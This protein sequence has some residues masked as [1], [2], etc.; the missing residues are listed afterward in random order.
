MTI[1]ALIKS[2]NV[3]DDLLPE[4][5]SRREKAIL[6]TNLYN[7]SFGQEKSK[8][9]AILATILKK[10]G[11]NVHFEPVFRCEF[12]SNI[13]LGDNFY[14]NYDCVMLDPHDI[15]I[16][17]NVIFGPRVSLFT[18]N[19]AIDSL[20]RIQGGCYAK[21]IHV[22]DNVWIGGNVTVLPGVTIGRNA[23]IGAGSVVTRSVPADVIA[24]GNPCRVIR[25]ITEK[26]KKQGWGKIVS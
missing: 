2:G 17:N 23:I 26:D 25:K 18:A 11:R 15:V 1:D 4:I 20:E 9:E 3:Y 24:A 19:H 10:I 16:G 14:A 22:E 5:V 8:R 6:Q 12:G 13:S 21:P 7:S